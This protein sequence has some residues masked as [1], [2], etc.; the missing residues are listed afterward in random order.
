MFSARLKSLIRALKPA[1]TTID[2]LTD[3]GAAAVPAAIVAVCDD[4]KV[5]GPAGTVLVALV[6]RRPTPAFR[7]AST[8]APVVDLMPAPSVRLY[9]PL[10]CWVGKLILKVFVNCGSGATVNGPGI[11]P[12]GPVIERTWLAVNV[13]GSIGR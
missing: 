8:A 13:V 11:G 10:S 6:K 1:G 3:D 9:V 5:D 7:L 12:V 4:E 2:V